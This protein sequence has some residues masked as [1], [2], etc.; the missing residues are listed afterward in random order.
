MRRALERCVTR[1]KK[2]SLCGAERFA[3]ATAHLEDP[4]LAARALPLYRENARF[5]HADSM[6]ALGQC[7]E[8]GAGCE[9]DDAEAAKWY[10]RA[11][12]LGH[13]QARYALGTYF[14]VGDGTLEENDYLALAFFAAA[15]ADG[16]PGAMYVLADCILEGFAG[17]DTDTQAAM[18][19]LLA[20][21]DKGH[22]G[23]RSKLF[24]LLEPRRQ[25]QTT[26][27]DTTTHS[28]FDTSNFTEKNASRQSIKRRTT[29]LT[30]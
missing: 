28:A 22:R 29:C 11:A 23:A 3:L 25:L 8:Q 20:A 14:Y 15:A 26:D 18:Q 17:L 13:D 1:A 4:S 7:Y 10:F 12:G 21:G 2:A 30:D 9:E 27:Q 5:G 16:H 6:C 19:W 24:A